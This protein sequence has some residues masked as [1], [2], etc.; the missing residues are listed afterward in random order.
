MARFYY[1]WVITGVVFLVGVT[2]AGAFQN[3]LAVFLKPMADTFGW[4]RTAISATMFFGS[5]TG[6]FISPFFG[7]LLDRH[8]PRIMAFLGVTILSAGL[9]SLAFLNNIWQLY[10]L[11]GIGRMVAVGVLN[12]VIS[13]SISNWF[14]RLRG[15]AMGMVW[16][17]PRMGSAV[18]PLLAQFLISSHGWRLAWAALGL[19]V[20]I[21]SGIPS[22]LFLRRRPE[23]LGLLPDGDPK[24]SD[25][26]NPDSQTTGAGETEP[27]SISNLEPIWTRREAA[28]TRSFWLLTVI[29]CLFTL[30]QAGT[31]FHLFPF[32]TDQGISES[33]GVMLI[34]TFAIF[35]AIGAVS[36]GFLT[37]KFSSTALLTIN[38]FA[39]GII[40][41]FLYLMITLK[42]G[43]AA[44]VTFLFILQA[45]NGLL[46]GGRMPL[47]Y[48]IWPE[49]FGRHSLGSI[50]SLSSTFRF[51]TNAISPMFTALFFD[52]YGDYSIPFCFFIFLYICTGIISLKLRPPAL[53]KNFEPDR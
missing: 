46:H 42:I 36:C 27:G 15:R 4:S 8:G 26:S 33:I 16:L 41:L 12:L 11:F 47:L 45:I 53:P 2:E 6:G 43:G 21:M 30:V 38:A 19:V 31:N 10:L 5:I 24:P 28:R 44:N 17:G 14:I 32:L 48:I 3:I 49:F 1:G 52:L 34:S 25:K 29:T 40:F 39:S 13:V 35:G 7:S 22:L 20:F 23:D 37:E 9:V 18:L 51:T 50:Q